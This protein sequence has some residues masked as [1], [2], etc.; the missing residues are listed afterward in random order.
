[1]TCV[2]SAT[3]LLSPLFPLPVL[4]SESISFGQDI[5]GTLQSCNHTGFSN[6]RAHNKGLWGPAWIDK[7]FDQFLE[8]FKAD[9]FVE[10]AKNNPALAENKVII[11]FLSSELARADVVKSLQVSTTSRFHQIFPLSL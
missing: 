10:F 5:N 4:Q 9:A 8:D 7:V 2:H 11:P 3:V 1:M 6:K